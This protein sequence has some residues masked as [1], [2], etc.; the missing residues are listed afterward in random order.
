MNQAENRVVM[1]ADVL[2]FAALVEGNTLNVEALK[3]LDGP[4]G[5]NIDN[6]FR[7]H[8]DPI[9]RV[10]SGFHFSVRA[11]LQLA[12]I[13]HRLTAITFS[14]SAFIA[15]NNLVEATEL[16][17]NLMQSLLSQQSPVRIAIAHGSFAAL[18]FISDITADGGDHAAHFL[19]TGVVRANAAEGC[20]IKGLRILLHRSAVALLNDPAH[21][22]LV[23]GERRVRIVNCTPTEISNL[24]GVTHEVDYWRFGRTAEADAWHAL[25][26]MWNDAPPTAV[27]HYEATAEAIERMRLGQGEP[28]LK[29]LR[30][31]TLPKRIQPAPPHGADWM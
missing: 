13:R 31:R 19:G 29:N 30:R 24:A 28:P 12:Q 9:A 1:F 5:S 3:A 18:R 4:I 25:Q 16:A 14:D 23:S 6:L 20:G 10:F 11:A 2:G 8:E 22:P 17:V 21:N 7:A 26:D 27:R 15:T